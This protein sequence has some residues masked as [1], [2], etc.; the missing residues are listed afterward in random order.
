[1]QSSLDNRLFWVNPSLKQRVTYQA[2]LNDL[3][4]LISIPLVIKEEDPYR[5]L[6]Y[7]VA[8]IL[9]E[10]QIELLDADFSSFE[11][12]S[13]GLD[14]LIE[15]QQ[16]SISL[17][18]IENI[19]A[20]QKRLSQPHPGFTLTLYT[21]GTTGRPKK[22][23][24]TY[25]NLTRTVKVNPRLAQAIWGFCYNPTHF[26]GLQV[27]FQALSNL[28]PLVC[29]FPID[30][31][32][33]QESIQEYGVTHLSATPTYFRMLLPVLLQPIQQVCSLTSGG[34]KFDPAFLQQL[35]TVFPNARIHNLYA[36]TEA[37]SLFSSEDDIFTI[38]AALHSLVR[39]T[40]EGELCIHQSLIGE[41]ESILIDNGWFHTG[42]IVELLSPSSFRFLSRITEMIN[43][44][45][46]K[47]NP[48]EVE[49]AICQ[50]PWVQDAVVKARSNRI[51][52]NI[53]TADIET[54]TVIDE[55]TAQLELIQYL[56][57]ILQPF[58]IPRIIHFVST[59]QLTRT[60]KKDRT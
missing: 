17:P 39:F 42:D 19:A 53:L 25:Q 47:V 3:T 35:R 44:G 23:S 58:K 54:N 12:Q 16:H 38:P 57:T 11:M 5:I 24:H 60:G 36:S 32:N 9:C 56:Q 29:L 55:S 8:A 14:D 50:L 10:K 48:H 34:E 40:P 41:S 15:T 22:V 2:F 33:V 28:N 26:A 37:G 52:G 51:T 7:L 30:P 4:S 45:G 27:F 59:L 49:T 43:V 21:S 46:Y 20:L 13:I 18:Q 31:S 1:M 6:L